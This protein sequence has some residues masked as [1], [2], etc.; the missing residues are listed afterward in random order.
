MGQRSKEKGKRGEREAAAELARLFGCH[1]RRGQQFSGDSTSPDVVCEIPGV[2][3]EVKRCERLQLW[4]AIE[5]ALRDCG[6][7]VP[8]VLHRPNHRPWIAIVP[9]DGLEN[10]AWRI[11]EFLGSRNDGNDSVF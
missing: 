4:P 6:E 9:L 10:L 7:S 3:I 11:V 1:A 5:Q 2:H 8:V